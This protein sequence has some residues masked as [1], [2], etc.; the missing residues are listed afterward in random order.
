MSTVQKGDL[1]IAL[2][3]RTARSVMGWSLKDLATKLGVGTSTVG[4]WENCELTMKATTYLYLI[5][6][7]ETDGFNFDFLE[8]DSIQIILSPEL[9]A[10]R[11]DA[12]DQK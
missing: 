1:K 12:M 5:K 7:L 2:I 9:V 3:I 8:D 10:K 11:M 4:K 6:I